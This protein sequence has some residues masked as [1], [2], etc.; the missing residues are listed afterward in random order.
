VDTVIDAV[1]LIAGGSPPRIAGRVARDVRSALPRRARRD[2]LAAARRRDLQPGSAAA[3]RNPA[4]SYGGA[5]KWSAATTRA[6][7][8][9]PPARRSIAAIGLT[10]SRSPLLAAPS[11]SAAYGSA[12]RSCAAEA[13]AQLGLQVGDRFGE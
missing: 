4:P 3:I 5:A 1:A 7:P 10:A 12:R 13:A 8:M 11:A 6:A 2:R 9:P